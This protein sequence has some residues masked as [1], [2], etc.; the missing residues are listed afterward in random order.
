GFRP[1]GRVAWI[2]RVRTITLIEARFLN[3]LP[4]KCAE[5]CVP[6]KAVAIAKCQGS[7][8]AG[9]DASAKAAVGFRP[10]TEVE[11]NTRM[12]EIA[13]VEKTALIVAAD[14]GLLEISNGAVFDFVLVAGGGG[15]VPEDVGCLG[16]ETRAVVGIGVVVGVITKL[17]GG[18]GV[19]AGL[20]TRRIGAANIKALF[21][22]EAVLMGVGF[23]TRELV[24]PVIS[25]DEIPHRAGTEELLVVLLVETWRLEEGLAGDACIT[26]V[27]AKSQAKMVGVTEGVAKISR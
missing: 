3:S 7:T 20:R 2:A 17:R 11:R 26:G 22:V 18:D 14:V 4:I 6:P 25:R 23:G 19:R 24:V 27:V 12:G 1:E 15:K 5:T 8:R 16:C 9:H 13:K 10:G 21:G